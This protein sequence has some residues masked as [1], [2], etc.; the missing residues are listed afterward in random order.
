[1]KAGN[2]PKKNSPLSEIGAHWIEK[3]FHFFRL[4]KIKIPFVE[5]WKYGPKDQF[6]LL[7]RKIPHRTSK[8]ALRP[9]QP[10]IQWVPKALSPGVKLT[11]READHFM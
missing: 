4:E 8:P 2:L 5:Q 6:C 3:Y 11:G 7:Q 9:T 10:H 1:V